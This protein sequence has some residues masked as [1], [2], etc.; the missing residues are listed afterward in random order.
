MFCLSSPSRKRHRIRHPSCTVHAK[1]RFTAQKSLTIQSKIRT[2]FFNFF[3]L[4]LC[5]SSARLI[6][7][8]ATVW[9]DW[10]RAVYTRSST[11]SAQHAYIHTL[12]RR[13][14]S[15]LN[16]TLVVVYSRN[17]RSEGTFI[18]AC[19]SRPGRVAHGS[20]DTTTWSVPIKI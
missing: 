19:G 11:T 7:H 18:N 15:D 6:V 12:Y 9:L 1:N 2:G 16:Y 10:S 13:Y 4:I 8:D 20:P 14:V 3:F 17:A 5:S